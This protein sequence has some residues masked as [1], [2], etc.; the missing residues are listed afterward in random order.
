[1]YKR[2][3]FASEVVI[4]DRVTGEAFP[5]RI[6]VN[7]PASYKGIEIYQSS[8]DDGGSSVKLQAIP[9]TGQGKPFEVNGTIGGSTE[10]TSA[11]MDG[12]PGEKLTLEYTALRVLNV[13]NF[14]GAG[15]SGADV[16]KVDLRAALDARMGL[17]LIHI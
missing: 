12:K 11:G 8:F 16:R 6:E 13:E 9:L 10:L 14:T 2:Q 4:H 1:M 17:S 3:L 15:T 5:E 7:H